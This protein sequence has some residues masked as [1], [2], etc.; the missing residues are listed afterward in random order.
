MSESTPVSPLAPAAFPDLPPVAGVLLA[1]HA[2]ELRYRGRPD[3]MLAALAP[4][5]RAAGVL[6]RSR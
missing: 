6:T 3:V 1:A 5:S 2:A 4:G